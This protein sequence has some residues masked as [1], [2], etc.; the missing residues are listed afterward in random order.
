[1]TLLLYKEDVTQSFNHQ[2]NLWFFTY[3]W[4]FYMVS[5]HKVF[6]FFNILDH[7]PKL[8]N[9]QTTMAPSTNTLSTSSLHHLI[10]SCSIKL[11]PTKH[12]LWR[13][14]MTQLIQMMR[15]TEIITEPRWPTCFNGRTTKKSVTGER[16][17]KT[18]ILL[19]IGRIRICYEGVGYK[20]PWHKKACTWL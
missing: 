11:K 18:T 4:E 9:Y 1:M 6:P 13:T 10:P 19:M 17:Q 7:N 20:A 8:P 5:G 15:L 14:Q 2:Y 16:V 12:L 3:L